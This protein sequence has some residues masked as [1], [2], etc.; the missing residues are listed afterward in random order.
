MKKITLSL[1]IAATIA[2]CIAAIISCSKADLIDPPTI[3]GRALNEY[4]VELTRGDVNDL[5]ITDSFIIYVNESAYG[6]FE[7]KASFISSETKFIIGDLNTLTDYWFKIAV[8]NKAGDGPMSAAVKVTT[9]D[10]TVPRTPSGFKVTITDANNPNG[11]RFNWENVPNADYYHIY[12]SDTEAG[13]FTKMIVNDSD[14]FNGWAN[15]NIAANFFKITAVNAKGESP[16]SVTVKA[17]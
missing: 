4:S 10:I 11:K 13:T 8:R 7:K 14:Q 5:K 15:V 3:T 17:K 12:R 6:I 16:Q 9:T 2:A 1:R